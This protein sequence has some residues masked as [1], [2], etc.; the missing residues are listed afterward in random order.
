[1]RER[2][3]VARPSAAQV[4]GEI[5]LTIGALLVLFVLY[6]A[7][8]TDLAS[9]RLQARAAAELDDR[10]AE[11]AQQ[12]GRVATS[13]PG[14]AFARVHLPTL[15]ADANYVVVEGTRK[16]DLRTGPGHYEETQLPGEP[17]NF[18]LAGHR[19]GSGGVFRHLDQLESCDAVVVE[20]GT[21]WLTYRLA[22][23]ETEPAAR[24][25]AAAR[26][27]SPQ[28][29]ERFTGGDYAHVQG[30][31][32]TA[33]NAVEV[34]A[35]LPGVT[36]AG[37]AGPE[38]ERILTLTTCHPLFSNTERLIVHAVLTDTTPTSAGLPDALK[39]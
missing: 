30:R 20:S 8:W 14:E 1:M 28:Q 11:D 35:P 29:V 7:F 38:L 2:S 15:G 39:E 23:V 24:R 3:P 5:L 36:A 19:N 22:P 16:D 31:H 12:P 10:W 18:A 9:D 34:V 4:A 17:G 25:D 32:V 33:P 27:L 6:E 21:Q 26:C 37:P 13:A